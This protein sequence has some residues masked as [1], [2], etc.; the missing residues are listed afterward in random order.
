M[1]DK[2]PPPADSGKNVDGS[3]LPLLYSR[4]VS[5]HILN[6]AIATTVFNKNP[7]IKIQSKV[8]SRIEWNFVDI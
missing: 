5:A 6:A 7:G 8:S 2:Q 3:E 4:I 1:A